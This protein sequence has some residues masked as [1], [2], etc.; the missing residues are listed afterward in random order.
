MNKSPSVGKCLGEPP[1]GFC[2]VGCC[3]CYL[4][5]GFYISG[6]LFLATGTPPWLSG[7]WRP[8]PA[9]SFYPGYFRLLC[10][11]Q[12]FPSQFYHKRHGF[13]WAFFTRR[14]FLP[15][16][17][18]PKSLARFVTQMRAS[19]IFLCACPHRVVPSGWR[20]GLNYSYCS[21]KTIDLSITLVSHEV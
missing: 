1:G 17:S 12:A 10:F 13:E 21:Y 3:C 16:A 5:G 2:D 7:P 8:P 20:L 9:L 6:L 15:Y 14:R 4:T 18:S 11:Y 19:K